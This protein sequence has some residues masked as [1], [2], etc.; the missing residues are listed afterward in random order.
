MI[1]TLFD[2][3]GKLD[4]VREL[5]FRD[6]AGASAD[7]GIPFF[8]VGACA[9]DLLLDLYY[10]IPA[11]RATND[12]DLG[13]RVETWNQFEGMKRSL[14]DTGRYTPD[15]DRPERLHSTQGIFIDVV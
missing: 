5:V 4:P 9:R 15:L 8:I 6:L 3:S 13:I 14:T 11:Y 12:I 7:L 1:D 2:L 10:R